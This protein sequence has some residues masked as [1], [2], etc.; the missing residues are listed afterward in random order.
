MGVNTTRPHFEKLDA[1]T[2]RAA[3]S[4]SRFPTVGEMLRSLTALP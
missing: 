1:R 3:S 2:C 4:E